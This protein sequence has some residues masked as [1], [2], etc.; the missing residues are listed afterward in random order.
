[1][2]RQWEGGS[3]LAMRGI[4][5]FPVLAQALRAGYQVHERTSEGFTVR[6]RTPNGWALAVVMLRP[7]S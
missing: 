1:M 7:T 2:E 3:K 6:T 5:V 4:V